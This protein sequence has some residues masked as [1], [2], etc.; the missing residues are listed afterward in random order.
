M[1]FQEKFSDVVNWIKANAAK[2]AANVKSTPVVASDN[3]QKVFGFESKEKGNNLLFGK[4]GI[5]PANTTT[6]FGASWGSGGLFNNQTPFSFGKELMSYFNWK[7]LLWVNPVN[8]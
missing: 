8:A 5:S 3:N 4:P 6:N 1:W 7:I 2:D